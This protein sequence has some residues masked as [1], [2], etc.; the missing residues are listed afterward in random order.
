M[1][2]KNPMGSAHRIFLLLFFALFYSVSSLPAQNLI[3]NPGFE[4]LFTQFEYQWVQ[5]QGPYYHY[6]QPDKRH[7]H[8]AHGGDFNNGICMYSHEPNEYL[9]VKL[10]DSL[11][12]G[13]K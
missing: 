2:Q 6:E 11:L 3:P 5:P 13:V 7:A 12:A 1:I 9:H 4:N 10:L 8:Q